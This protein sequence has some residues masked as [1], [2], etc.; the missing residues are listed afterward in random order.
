MSAPPSAG[1]QAFTESALK[2]APSKK[3]SSSFSSSSSSKKPLRK[4]P[5]PKHRKKAKGAAIEFDD[6]ARA[7]F[8]TGFRKRKQARKEAGREFLKQKMKE[9][10]LKSRAEAR[11]ARKEKAA[12][13]V[14]AEKAH[15]GIQEES[16]DEDDE[17]DDEDQGPIQEEEYDSDAH[18]TRVVVEEFNPE[19]EEEK[20][21][22]ERLQKA[23]QASTKPTQAPPKL[24]ATEVLPPSS[25]RAKKANAKEQADEDASKDEQDKN[26]VKRRKIHVSGLNQNFTKEDLRERFSTFGT[27]HEVHGWPEAKDANGR[28]KPY[29]FISMDASLASIKKCVSLLSGTTW[30]GAKLRIG[31]ARPDWMERHLEEVRKREEVEGAEGSRPAKKRRLPPFVGVEAMSMEPINESRVKDGE[32][33]W[34]KLED[35]RLV[36]P[37]VLRPSHPIGK[38]TV[39]PVVKKK[40]EKG[41]RRPKSSAVPP[42][43]S[44]RITIDPSRYGS[45]HYDSEALE[46]MA[47]ARGAE[48]P[49]QLGAGEWVCEE[50]A[51][52]EDLFA[53]E[54]VSSRLIKW[55][56]VGKDGEVLR[57]ESFKVAVR[58]K[59]VD[60]EAQALLDQLEGGAWLD[61]ESQVAD[62]GDQDDQD[63]EIQKVA[64]GRMEDEEEEDNL[65]DQDLIT[66]ETTA[67]GSMEQ[68]AESDQGGKSPSEDD[69][70]EA[71]QEVEVPS[72]PLFDAVPAETAN[73]MATS[74]TSK[75]KKSKVALTPFIPKAPYDPDAESD[76]SDGYEEGGAT[77]TFSGTTVAAAGDIEGERSKALGLLGNLFGDDFLEADEEDAEIEAPVV[78]FTQADDATFEKGEKKATKG[79]V[80]SGSNGKGSREVEGSNEERT[81]DARKPKSS[82]QVASRGHDEQEEEREEEEEEEKEEEEEEEEEEAGDSKT[83]GIEPSD[84]L[85]KK[86]AKK[87]TNSNVKMTSLKDMFKPQEGSGGFSLI[88][89]LTD[90][91]DL[92]LDEE[93]NFGPDVQDDDDEE[94]GRV[95]PS[96]SSSVK[97]AVPSSAFT[98]GAAT[99][100]VSKGFFDPDAS[101]PFLFLTLSKD[102][103]AKQGKRAMFDHVRS[104]GGQNNDEVATYRFQ[105]SQTQEEIRK[106]WEDQRREL[107]NDYKRRHREAVKKKRRKITGSRA[108]GSTVVGGRM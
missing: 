104:G 7:E 33:G 66:G 96:S 6:A 44:K 51:E 95:P 12:E 59:G 35:G 98:S 77:R 60:D 61:E 28:Q 13:N 58:P 90:E 56:Y 27:I 76:F 9:E 45:I 70:V 92:D 29:A 32:W 108:A 89:G 62:A 30:K 34:K 22:L 87:D 4:V 67:T 38:P 63:E 25:A 5:A 43:R 42:V 94:T 69:E 107:T 84:D 48:E 14:A 100:A 71:E 103:L 86:D 54:D 93:L 105:R 19:E 36:R 15:Y 24:S 68:M 47:S 81:S 3:K 46:E 21:E 18:H 20:A 102:V 65:F 82:N 78:D 83:D 99:A 49:E 8:L 91:L 55:K 80:E 11:E 23:S 75:S 106:R 53:S 16:D 31:E 74:S 39:S 72:S 10:H 79:R 1:L 57:E 85:A 26:Q 2:N 41:Q 101:L 40:L 64:E 37:L 50:I 73:T 17:V 88:G 97:L 52:E